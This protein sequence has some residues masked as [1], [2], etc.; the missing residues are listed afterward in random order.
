G[1][2]RVFLRWR[3][4][5]ITEGLRIGAN[6]SAAVCLQANAGLAFTG[7]YPLGQG[8]V[9]LPDQV[10]TACGRD[11]NASTVVKPFII[12]RDLTQTHR[13]ASIIDFY[14]LQ[15]EQARKQFPSLFQWVYER[16]RPERKQ[17]KV[18]ERRQNWWLFTRPIP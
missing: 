12:A 6:I 4:G 14:P 16:V 17:N 18:K 5:P 10:E 15:K 11:E 2:K 9:L 3:I 1:S 13:K 8:F 7:M